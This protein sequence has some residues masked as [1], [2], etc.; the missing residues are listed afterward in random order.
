MY[1]AN[2]LFSSRGVQNLGDNV[3][4]IAIDKIYKDHFNLSEKEICYINK[5][6]LATYDGKEV[7]LPVSLAMVDYSENGWAGRFSEKITP[8]FLGLSI[9]KDFFTDQEVAFF[10][11]HEPVG[12]RDERTYRTMCKYNIAAYLAGCIT[13]TFPDREQKEYKKVYAVDLAAE[14]IEKLPEFLK[15]NL[16]VTSHFITDL[17]VDP[18]KKMQEQ[19]DMYINNAKC[20]ITPLL[21]CSVPCLAAGIPVI[22]VKNILSYRFAWIDKLL[23]IYTSDTLSSIKGF[24][25]KVDIEYPRKLLTELTVKR[26]KSPFE[27]FPEMELLTSFWLDREQKKY[28][29][30]PFL[31]YLRFME[32][33][34]KDKNAPY[35]YS[36]WGVTQMSEMIVEYCKKNYPNAR[37]KDVYDKY[38]RF[39]FYGIKTKSS[40]YVSNDVDFIFVTSNGP[41]K[42]ARDMIAK[43]IISESKVCFIKLY[44]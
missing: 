30:D 11:K 37:L 1:Y 41:E 23:K 9:A 19:Y 3:Q 33:N 26:L 25:E 40:E 10:K 35:T 22:C 43:N 5:N 4:L 6:D 14:D 39:D 42:D 13:L 31:P 44:K 12:C 20:V 27:T 29:I 7:V 2:M 21:H 32:N 17:S 34:M 28:E 8:V 38:K 36:I 18:K 16:E 15:E 24:P